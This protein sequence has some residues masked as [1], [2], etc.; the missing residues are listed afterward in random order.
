MHDRDRY[1]SQRRSRSGSTRAMR[2]G[3]TTNYLGYDFYQDA[4]YDHPVDKQRPRLVQFC[5]SQQRPESYDD[6]WKGAGR[7]GRTSRTLPGHRSSDGQLLIQRESRQVRAWHTLLTQRTT[8]Q[9]DFKYG[10]TLRAF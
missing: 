3:A 8:P 4:A 2:L 1:W 5:L 9:L 10:I 6:V 7:S